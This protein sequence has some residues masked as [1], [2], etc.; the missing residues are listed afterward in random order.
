M[1]AMKEHLQWR[2]ENPELHSLLTA[3][4]NLTALWYARMSGEV[5]WKPGEKES[6]GELMAQFSEKIK[7]LQGE[8]AAEEFANL[9]PENPLVL[10]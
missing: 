8:Q 3:E 4:R 7:R 2:K 6:M 5:A 1:T 10:I 9:L